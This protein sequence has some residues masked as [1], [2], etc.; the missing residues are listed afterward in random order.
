MVFST[1]QFMGQDGEMGGH[2]PG[3]GSARSE[4]GIVYTLIR[5]VTTSS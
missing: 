1:F 3:D 4:E 5:G 2:I